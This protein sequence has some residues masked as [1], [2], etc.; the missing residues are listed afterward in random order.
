MPSLAGVRVVTTCW[1]SSVVISPTNPFTSIPSGTDTVIVFVKVSVTSPFGFFISLTIVIT[2]P[3][4]TSK[5]G[6]SA[7][8]VIALSHS[9]IVFST[10]LVSSFGFSSSDSGSD[11]DSLSEEDASDSSFLSGFSSLGSS[12]LGS[13]SLGFFSTSLTSSL[14]SL[15]TSAATSSI[16]S[17]ATSA[18]TLASASGARIVNKW[19]A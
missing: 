17:L 2:F 10:S 1:P 8:I 11:S 18:S 9:L 13:S 3:W 14:T 4:S 7:L 5:S 6:I 16:T 19:L 15:L 12:F